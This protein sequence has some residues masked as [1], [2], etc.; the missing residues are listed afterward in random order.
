MPFE[1][2]KVKFGPGTLYA[3]PV[4]TVEPVDLTTAWATVAPAWT[5]LGYTDEGH[6]FTYSP[7]FDPVEVAEALL[8]IRSVQ[9]G[10]E[11]G[12]EFALAEM[13]AKNLQYAFNGGTIVTAT[14]IT[15][16]EPP[17]ATDQAVRL[18]IGWESD[19]D[20]DTGLV[21]ERWVYRKCLQTGDVAIA[22][23]KAP[24][25]ATIPMNLTLEEVTGKK[26]FKR[27]SNET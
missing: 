15:T 17:A 11:A 22:R 6:T 20:P 23:Q 8:R 27:V 12:L 7:S 10:L 24:N 5:A 9:T 19:K 25:K 16:F 3:A 13:T 2:N 4:G 18:A 26:P 14:G 21:T 1:V